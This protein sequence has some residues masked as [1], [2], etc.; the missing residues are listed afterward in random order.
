MLVDITTE[1]GKTPIVIQLGKTGMVYTFHRDTGDPYFEIEELPVPTDGILGDQLSPTQPFPV[2]PPPLV[3]QG[4]TPDDA[5]GVTRYERE[6]CRK[7][8]AGS[9]YGGMFTPM[10]T[11]GTVMYP[12]VGG[13]SNWGGG[14]KISFESVTCVE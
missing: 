13:G 6:A 8:I 10:S 14:A 7:I 5:W 2:K 4:I 9:R 1:E 11:K 3:R 12:Q